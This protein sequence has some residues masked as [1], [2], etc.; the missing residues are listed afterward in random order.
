[1]RRRRHGGGFNRLHLRNGRLG[2]GAEAQG[3]A[4][5][6]RGGGDVRGLDLVRD[7]VAERGL[8][9]ADGE[10]ALDV[11]RNLLP[12]PPLCDLEGQRPNAHVWPL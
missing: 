1:M 9:A 12:P 6:R 2:N 3:T 11:P 10:E 4:V 8:L 7:V 5:R